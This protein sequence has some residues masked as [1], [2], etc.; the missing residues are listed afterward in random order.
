MNFR[1]SDWFAANRLSANIPA[2]YLIR[3]LDILSTAT[4]FISF[5]RD[6]KLKTMP[7][8]STVITAEAECFDD[9]TISLQFVGYEVI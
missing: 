5:L 4:V 2:F 1:L 3:K 6:A 7:K 9:I 8:N